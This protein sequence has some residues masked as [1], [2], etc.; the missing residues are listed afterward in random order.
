LQFKG[1]YAWLN[2]GSEFAILYIALFID[3]GLRIFER[4]LSI[5]YL[6]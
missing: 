2:G 1:N 4:M 5:L 6:L 3:T